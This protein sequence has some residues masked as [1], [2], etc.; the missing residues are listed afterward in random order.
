MAA[1]VIADPAHRGGMSLAAA[2]PSG[3]VVSRGFGDCPGAGV[4]RPWDW[5]H[6]P[7]VVRPGRDR[8]VC[9]AHGARCQDSRGSCLRVGDGRGRRSGGIR[10]AG[11]S[12]SP[13][14]SAQPFAV[15]S[16]I[17]SSGTDFLRHLWFVTE[18]RQHRIGAL[19]GSPLPGRL[20][21]A[22]RLAHHRPGPPANSQCLVARCRPRGHAHA[23][24]HASLAIMATAGRLTR[25][26]LGPGEARTSLRSWQRIVFIQTAWFSTFLSF[27]NVMNMLVAVVLVS[28]LLVGL[29]PG[30][31]GSTTG[32]LVC[33]C[34]LAVVANAWPLLDACDRSCGSAVDRPVPAARAL[35]VSAT[36]GSGS[37]AAAVFSSRPTGVGGQDNAALAAVPTL[38]NLFRP[39][40][41]WVVARVRVS[42]MLS[43]R[44]RTAGLGGDVLWR[45]G[46]GG[47]SWLHCAGDRVDMGT[48]ALLPRQG[49]VDLDDPGDPSGG[50][51]ELLVA[52]WPC[53]T[54]RRGRSELATLGSWG[55]IG[56]VVGIVVA[57]RSGSGLAFPAAPCDDRTRVARA[58]PN[59]S[60]ALI[61]SMEEVPDTATRNGEGPSSSGWFHRQTSEASRGLRWDR[62]LHGH[63]GASHAGVEGAERHPSRAGSTSAT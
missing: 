63:G 10:P 25:W 8:A 38:S 17:N 57:G 47:I 14:S 40:W 46:D 59:W 12:G 27:G 6:G 37:L 41:W 61:D 44:S 15:W 55:T 62:G 9:L 60:L 31:F 3:F 53:S 43:D 50:Q 20:A 33:A 49:P 42:P 1:L 7:P 35:V 54:A 13:C 34:S 39:D 2:V 22:G 48:D 21:S 29:Q 5:P 26:I 18:L 58:R 45:L 52:S 32:T 30:A 16:R 23:R 11:A 28:I 51:S 56:L 24:A 4:R 36:G 19:R